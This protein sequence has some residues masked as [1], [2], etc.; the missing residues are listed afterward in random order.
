M[1]DATAKKIIASLNFS[2]TTEISSNS[3]TPEPSKNIPTPNGKNDNSQ[4]PKKQQNGHSNVQDNKIQ[5]EKPFEENKKQL[6]SSKNG[7]NNYQKN[8]QSELE[9]IDNLEKAALFEAEGNPKKAIEF[10]S[11]AHLVRL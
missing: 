8:E 11:K 7:L 4:T 6:Q 10:Y 1:L 5:L 9:L 3:S 2:K